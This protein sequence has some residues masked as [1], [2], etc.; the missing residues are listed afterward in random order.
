MAQT[1][2]ETIKSVI[3]TDMVPDMEVNRA[4]LGTDLRAGNLQQAGIDEAKIEIDWKGRF[5]AVQDVLGPF[6]K[7]Q[8]VVCRA[9]AGLSR[10]SPNTPNENNSLPGSLR[11]RYTNG[12]QNTENENTFI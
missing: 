12:G 9:A 6:K 2:T 7:F 10:S 3:G 1:R 11:D 8:A 4:V 5:L